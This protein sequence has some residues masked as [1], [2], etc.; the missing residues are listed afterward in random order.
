[1]TAPDQKSPASR[2]SDPQSPEELA[3]DTSRSERVDKA[4]GWQ[5]YEAPLARAGNSGV[6]DVTGEDSAPPPGAGSYGGGRG[7]DYDRDSPRPG[8]LPNGDSEAARRPI[9]RSGT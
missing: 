9:T 2:R 5:P 3:M 1:M 8:K 6:G 4:P 7:T